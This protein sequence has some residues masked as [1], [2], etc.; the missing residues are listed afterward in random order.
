VKGYLFD[1]CAISSLLNQAHQ[2]HSAAK[3][4]V[5]S[6]P[7]GSLQFVSIVTIGEMEL[8]LKMAEQ[9]NSAHLVQFRSR[10]KAIRAYPDLDLTKHTASA[11]AE[12]KSSLALTV[13]KKAN[14]QKH[15]RWL[16]DWIDDNTGK[17]LQID[18]ND[19]WVAAQAKERDFTL[20]SGDRDMLRLSQVDNTVRVIML[21]KAGPF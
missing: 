16:E 4:V 21:G 12:L 1:T 8:G 18:E 6:L 15:S 3:A 20:V 7:R 9:A 17:K 5:A 2:H 14:A 11:Y 19:L 13:Q 10:I